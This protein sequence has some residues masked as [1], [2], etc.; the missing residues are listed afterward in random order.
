MI[1]RNVSISCPA[2]DA[3]TLL[4]ND[5]LSNSDQI[6]RAQGSGLSA[7]SSLVS[8][9]GALGKRDVSAGN[10]KQGVEIGQ[11]PLL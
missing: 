7:Q 5:F 4:G 6:L 8:D 11:Q 10:W 3:E 2:K 9:P 1:V